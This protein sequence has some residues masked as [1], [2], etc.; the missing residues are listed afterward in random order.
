M[1]SDDLIGSPLY[2]VNVVLWMTQPNNG[3]RVAPVLARAGYDTLYIERR[4]EMPIQVQNAMKKAGLHFVN[5][6]SPDLLL[7]GKKKAFAIIECKKTMFGASSSVAPQARSLLVQA[8]RV[9]EAAL[10]KPGGS[11]SETHV[12][13]LT[14]SEL[15]RDQ[16]QGL[17]ELQAELKAAKIA[18]TSCGLL[19]LAAVTDGVELSALGS[20]PPGIAEQVDKPVKVH[21]FVPGTDPRP[22]YIIPWLPDSESDRDEYNRRA[23][24]ERVKASAAEIIARARTGEDV[25]IK[26][27]AIISKT[28]L[29]FSE[30]WMNNAAKKRLRQETKAVL[31]P[32]FREAAKKV[33]V[34]SLP[35]ADGW[36]ITLKDD[37]TREIVMDALRG[38]D[39]AVD[40][41]QLPLISQSTDDAPEPV[42]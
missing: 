39:P 32:R 12:I 6:P 42:G 38:V 25:E 4:L 17:T 40:Y 30:K 33:A 8:P 10:A 14:R 24:A 2:Q 22:L 31:E 16:L 18:V 7:A 20:V 35:N 28:T 36:T 11:V 9:F 5:P 26:L 27:G 1:T 15:G 21:E 23:F 3:A 13:Y 29:G 41:R 37:D 19:T 34:L